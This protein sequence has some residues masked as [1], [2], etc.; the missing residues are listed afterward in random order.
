MK[1]A[2]FEHVNVTVSDPKK[3]AAMLVDLFGWHVRWEGPAKYDGYTV[4]VGTDDEYIALYALPKQDRMDEES[5]YRTGA[6]NHFGILVED[7]DAAEQRILKSGLKTHS[8]Q[9]YDP[10]SRFYFHDHDGIEWEVVSYV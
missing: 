5:Y 7:L 9:T 1:P 10:G 8:H 6:V 3:T 2:L 4:H